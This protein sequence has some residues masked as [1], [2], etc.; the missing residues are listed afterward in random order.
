M[1]IID[2]LYQFLDYKGVKPTN[3][4]KEIGLSNGY[5]SVQK[6]RSADVGEGVIIKIIENCRDISLSWLITGEGDMLNGEVDQKKFESDDF[7]NVPITD[8]SAAAGGGT[9]NS[10]Y[11]NASGVIKLPRHMLKNGKHLCVN[12]DG[13]SMEPTITSGSQLIVRLFDKS[14]WKYIKSGDVYVITDREGATYVKR[15][16]N[17][18][19]D[20]GTIKLISDN[21]NK[22][23]YSSFSLSENEIYNVWEVEYYLTN[24]LPDIDNNLPLRVSSLEND[25]LEI[26]TLLKKGFKN[27]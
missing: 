6:K 25:I 21:D 7:I 16:E 20:S 12:V 23:S 3:F 8:I 9:S 10:D 15:V 24:K 18:L 17:N 26:K 11:L 27:C 1:K 19:S 2:R 5:L 13:R 14:E 4:E 22:R